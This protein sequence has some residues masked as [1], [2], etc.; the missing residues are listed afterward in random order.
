DGDDDGVQDRQ[1]VPD[2]G[3]T[4]RGLGAL[5]LGGVPAGH[6]VPQPADGQE[7]RRQA[8]QD[9]GDPVRD[10]ADQLADRRDGQHVTGGA[11]QRGLRCGGQ[12]SGGGQDGDGG[13]GGEP[14]AA[15]GCPA[16]AAG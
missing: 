12:G 16:R 7:Q 14:G 6:Q 4:Q 1:A 8:G 13:A 10:V 15:R 11:G 9:P 5:H 3:G 2:G